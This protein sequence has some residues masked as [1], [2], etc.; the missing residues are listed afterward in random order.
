MKVDYSPKAITRRLRA[1]DELRD[2]C[3]TLAG[4][5]LK[6]PFRSEAEALA[7]REKPGEAENNREN[8]R[9]VGFSKQN[10]GE[11]R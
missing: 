4:P 9:K 10:K 11:R 2:L 7:V 5:R 8:N 3:R 6:I 1:V